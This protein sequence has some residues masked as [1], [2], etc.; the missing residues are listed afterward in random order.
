MHN[1]NY[2]FLNKYY[3]RQTR[4]DLNNIINFNDVKWSRPWMNTQRQCQ[5]KN[6]IQKLWYS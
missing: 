4:S 1:I 5:L 2:T 3:W 6:N